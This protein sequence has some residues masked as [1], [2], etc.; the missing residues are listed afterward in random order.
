MCLSAEFPQQSFSRLLN[1]LLENKCSIYL[2]AC[3][4]MAAI[5]VRI[6]ARSWERRSISALLVSSKTIQ[7]GSF[8]SGCAL[9]FTNYSAV[10]N[11]HVLVLWSLINIPPSTRS[12]LNLPALKHNLPGIRDTRVYSQL[13]AINLVLWWAPAAFGAEP[14][15][16]RATIHE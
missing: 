7:F 15:E 10:H 14:L 16:L 3:K 4:R 2:P 13:C 12:T 1:T 9:T 8:S 5:L 11:H 6:C